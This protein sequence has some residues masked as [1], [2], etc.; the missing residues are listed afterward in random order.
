MSVTFFIKFKV[1]SLLPRYFISYLKKSASNDFSHSN[2]IFLSLGSLS[3]DLKFIAN[4]GA[5]LE[6]RI[7]TIV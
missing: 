7:F 1:L 4:G 2:F 3:K 6:G 5:G